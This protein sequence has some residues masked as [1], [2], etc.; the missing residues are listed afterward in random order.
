[1]IFTSNITKETT[2][3]PKSKFLMMGLFDSFAGVL[4]LFGGVHTAGST[5]ALLGNSIIPITMLLSVI[6]L[7]T[8]FKFNHYFGAFVIMCGV[9]A[10]IAP[11][12][13]SSANTGGDEPLFNFIFVLSVVPSA[14][15]S[16]YK[17][18]IFGDVDIGMSY[19]NHS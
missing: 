3:F 9:L 15:S 8:P 1:M 18:L 7:K 5:Q 14:F 17:Q 10:V 11:Q 19:S 16:I 2:D 13:L 12:L 6:F 4:M